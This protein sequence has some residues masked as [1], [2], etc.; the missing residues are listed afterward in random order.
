MYRLL[1]YRAGGYLSPSAPRVEH[2]L[3]GPLLWN[4]SD[5]VGQLTTQL[6]QRRQSPL[7]TKPCALKEPGLVSIGQLFR[8]TPH[9]LQDGATCN[10]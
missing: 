4:P 5:L 10:R 3:V 1:I 2:P 9:S 8:Q 7:L 6:P